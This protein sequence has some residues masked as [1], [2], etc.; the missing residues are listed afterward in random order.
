MQLLESL[1]KTCKGGTLLCIACNIS[2]DDQFI[3]TRSI[4]DW[5]KEK[6]DLKKKP[7]V[8]LVYFKNIDL[9]L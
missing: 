8:F 7:T 2:L 5:K 9:E 3:K 1:L 6:V 4:E